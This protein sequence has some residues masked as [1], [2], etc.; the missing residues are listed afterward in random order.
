MTLTG[1]P[2][3][4]PECKALKRHQI[5]WCGMALC[6]LHNYSRDPVREPRSY[7][8]PRTQELKDAA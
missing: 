2:L 3:I 6:C 8:M 1:F 7:T 5:V 4:D